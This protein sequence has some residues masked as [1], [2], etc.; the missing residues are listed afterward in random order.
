MIAAS[1]TIGVLILVVREN[2]RGF[3]ADIKK[4]FNKWSDKV[5]KDSNNNREILP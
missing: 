5:C 4:R 3:K 2:I 1:M